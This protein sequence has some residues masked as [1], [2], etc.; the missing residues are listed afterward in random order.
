[1]DPAML[2]RID[3]YKHQIDA[4][5][6]FG[7]EL[8]P[9]I[10]AYYRVGLTYASN[11]L[12]GVSYT[13]SET[14][15][16]LEEGLT[17]GGKPLRDALAVTGHARAYDHMFSLLQNPSIR[18]SDLT[19]MHALLAGGLE[20]GEAGVY[21]NKK[22]FVTGTSFV[23]PSPADVP[24]HMD[25]LQQWMDRERRAMHPVAFA[26]RL[27]LRFVNIHP[28]MD[29]NGRIARLAMNTALIQEGYT[30]LVIPPVLRAEYMDAIR[31][32][33]LRDNDGA[34]VSLMCRCEIEG[35]K[36]LLRM[37]RGS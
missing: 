3:S 25:E 14:K 34:F 35:Q 26:A 32:A 29:G 11:A 21:R 27:H 18:L 7:P 10:Q 12:E 30:L 17:V 19:D 36:E 8:L 13:E 24:K 23:F 20:L 15:V 5:R 28:F 31:Q 37:L 2:T 16:L 22:I 6:P 33:Q 9:D 4:Y 1:M